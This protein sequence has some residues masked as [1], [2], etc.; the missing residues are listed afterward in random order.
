MDNDTT[1]TDYRA[2]VESLYYDWCERVAETE[3]EAPHYALH[4]IVDGSC[5]VIYTHAARKVIEHSDN[6]CAYFDEMGAV[7][8]SDWSTLLTTAAYF[9]LMADIREKG[10]PTDLDEFCEFAGLDSDDFD[11]VE[12]AWETYN[13]RAR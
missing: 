8:V 3:G 13:N 6:D 12:E 1:Y 5:W 11:S 2:A 4:E 7:E 10:D 9:A